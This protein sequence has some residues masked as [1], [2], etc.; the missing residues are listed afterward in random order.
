MNLPKRYLGEDAL[1]WL[2]VVF[3]KH[4]TRI[5]KTINYDNALFII[6]ACYILSITLNVEA[7]YSTGEFWQAVNIF[8]R[9]PASVDVAILIEFEW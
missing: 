9:S 1:T 8:H 7:L 5:W 4:K 2:T 6:S 3:L